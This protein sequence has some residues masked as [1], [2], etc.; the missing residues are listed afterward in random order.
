MPDE[1]T[2]KE[3]Y[4]FKRE[5]ITAF[6]WKY[7]VGN[8]EDFAKLVSLT[9]EEYLKPENN[10]E[11]RRGVAWFEKYDYLKPENKKEWPHVFRL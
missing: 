4:K 3:L 7:G 6:I 2:V 8:T 9:L 5:L 11:F 1:R 10:E